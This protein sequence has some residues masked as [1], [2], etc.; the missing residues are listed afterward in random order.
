MNNEGMKMVSYGK[1]KGT[2]KYDLNKILLNEKN[3]C[4]VE[5]KSEYYKLM[6]DIDFKENELSQEQL[7][8]ENEITEIII[9]KIDKEITN[10]F[11]TPYKNYVV[12]KKNKGRGTHLY[13]PDIIINKETHLELYN[14]VIKD[15]KIEK[16]EKY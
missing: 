4:F 6:W 12:C 8:K 1:N 5:I 10:M 13:Y 15:L 9:K 7:N 2:Y 3:Y 16:K 11:I 14:K